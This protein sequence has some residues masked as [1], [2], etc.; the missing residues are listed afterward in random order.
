MIKDKKPLSVE[1][2]M[3]DIDYILCIILD[4][5][6]LKFSGR[7]LKWRA[8]PLHPRGWKKLTTAQGYAKVLDTLPSL[9]RD[10]NIKEVRV[11]ERLSNFRCL[12]SYAITKQNHQ[13]DI[14]HER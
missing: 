4:D 14:N 7:D 11:C 6:T 9:R 10:W 13:G 8:N 3:G 1:D 12:S 5:N 2:V